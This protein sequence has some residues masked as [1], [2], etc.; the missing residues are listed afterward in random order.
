MIK[1]DNWHIENEGEILARQYDNLSRK[2]V[3]AGDIPEGYTWD[4]LVQTGGNLNIIRLSVMDGGIGVVLTAEMLALSGQ[5]TLQLRG[6]L[7]ADGVT[8]R[9]SNKIGVNIPD[10]LSGDEQWPE[11]PSEF[12]QMEQRM[13][14]LNEHP[15]TPGANGMWMIWNPDTGEY[16]ESDI[17]LPDGSGYAIG[18]GLKIVDGKLTVDTA[19]E[20]EEDNTRPVTSGAV[21]VQLGNVEALLENI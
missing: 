5:Y 14:D 19:T 18:D 1:F 8:V 6:T 4:L 16:E 15:P 13:E 9:H 17:P 20:V 21:Y 2:L 7:Q 3:I 11:I 10:S 12:T